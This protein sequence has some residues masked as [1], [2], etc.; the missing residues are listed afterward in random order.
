[1]NYENVDISL[2]NLLGQ[3]LSLQK[4][5]I[6]QSSDINSTQFMF[7]LIEFINSIGNLIEIQS[8]GN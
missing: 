1:M 4:Q 3:L 6:Y 5:L 2:V 8:K 7:A